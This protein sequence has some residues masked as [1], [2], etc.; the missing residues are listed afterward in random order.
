VQ[1]VPQAL[2]VT[3]PFN[4]ALP[5]ATSMSDLPL[6]Q[7]DFLH[8]KFW[9]K[10]DWMAFQD[11]KGLSSLGRRGAERSKVKA[12]QGEN[13]T[14]VFVKDQDGKSIDGH[15]A[16]EIHRIAQS[17][18]AE[19]AKKGRA[20]KSWCKADM[21]T[22]QEY[23][24]EMRRFFP[25]LGFCKF[26]WKAEQ[27]AIGNYPSWYQHH[28]KDKE[29][30][31][32]RE[33][34]DVILDLDSADE[35]VPV[36]I[37][38][39]RSDAGPQTTK[40]KK[41]S[42]NLNPPIEQSSTTSAESANTYAQVASNTTAG[43]TRVWKATVSPHDFCLRDSQ[44]LID[45]GFVALLSVPKPIVSHFYHPIFHANIRQDPPQCHENAV[46]SYCASSITSIY[47]TTD[48]HS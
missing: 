32:K 4:L 43:L 17:I 41:N 3:N 1:T 9:H 35:V 25:E 14:M 44:G 20:P 22:V 47:F 8:V 10:C 28:S 5:T 39:S 31:V 38:Q 30:L 6:R 15:R 29:K 42:V 12:S 40:R 7:S 18:W 2:V 13:I 46:S 45:W 37:K 24:H 16:M 27:I 23:N 36:H 48:S 33:S 34:A 11:T 21:L 26:N 19:L